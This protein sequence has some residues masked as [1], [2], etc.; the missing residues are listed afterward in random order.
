MAGQVYPF[1]WR[2]CFFDGLGT[3]VVHH[4]QCGLVVACA[5]DGKYLGEGRDEQGIG[6]AWHGSH[7]DGVDV[8]DVRQKKYCI[9]FNN[10]TGKAPV[11][12]VYIVPVVA[13]ARAVKQ[14]MS[15][16]MQASCVGD[17]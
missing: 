15:C 8:V 5:E 3:L 14:K 9:F 13:S 2:Q 10:S 12:L 16:I 7:D 6:A 11:R 4:V 17:I 1:C